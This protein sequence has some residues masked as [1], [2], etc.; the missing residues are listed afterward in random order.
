MTFCPNAG[1]FEQCR[2]R[3]H[4]LIFPHSPCGKPEAR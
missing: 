1:F 4:S 2:Q 3:S